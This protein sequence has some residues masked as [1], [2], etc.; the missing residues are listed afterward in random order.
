MIYVYIFT[1]KSKICT[2]NL[3]D[4]LVVLM[5]ASKAFRAEL[6]FICIK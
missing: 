2:H 1:V 6:F 3:M 4:L 5:D